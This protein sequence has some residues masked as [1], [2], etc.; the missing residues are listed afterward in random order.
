MEEHPAMGV[1]YSQSLIVRLTTLLLQ[2]RAGGVNPIALYDANFVFTENATNTD[3]TVYRTREGIERFFI[4][5]IN[6]PASSAQAQSEIAIMHDMLAA[7][8][9]VYESTV[10]NHVPGGANVQRVF[11]GGDRRC[12]RLAITAN[13]TYRPLRLWSEIRSAITPRLRRGQ[14]SSCSRSWIA[15][16]L[17][18]TSTPPRP[19]SASLTRRACRIPASVSWPTRR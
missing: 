3:V 4:T 1:D 8:T 15:M 7:T 5:D 17:P 18:P 16:P 13:V 12:T 9:V 11:R 10:A 6:N 2:A 19:P 14:C